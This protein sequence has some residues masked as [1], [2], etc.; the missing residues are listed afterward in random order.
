[1]RG[2]DTKLMSRNKQELNSTYPELIDLL[3]K[4]DPRLIVDGEIVAF[5]GKQ[6]SFS[7]LQGRMKLHDAD[8]ARK[9][10]IKVYYYLFDILFLD[11][12]DLTAL[13]LRLR[14]RL[15][16]D[17]VKFTG[18]LRY[19]THRNEKGKAYHQQA[20]KKGWEGVIAKDAQSAY[21]HSRSRQWLKFKCINQQ[22]LVIGGYT[23]PGGSRE[24]FGALLVG[25]YRDDVLHYAGKVGTGFDDQTLEELGD[26]LKRHEIDDCPFSEQQAASHKGV[27]WVKP[28]L[29]AEIG[30]TEWTQDGRLRHPRYIGLRHDKSAKQVVREEP[31]PA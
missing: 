3:D 16:K 14:K 6:T 12:Y 29:V 19:T 26:R 18:A 13:P 22:E 15:L 2:G 28:S 1:V 17:A 10:N 11:G 7:R 24:A 25:Y 30:F 9:S 4:Q 5:S 23:D 21:V 20:C 8:K 27:H 31:Q